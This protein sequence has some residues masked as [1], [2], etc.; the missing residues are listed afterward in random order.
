MSDPSI[1]AP[2]DYNIVPGYIPPDTRIRPWCPFCTMQ[3]RR[4]VSISKTEF[5][6]SS[7]GRKFQKQQ[8]KDELQQKREHLLEMF[9]RETADQAL[10]KQKRSEFRSK[11]R[12]LTP[13]ELDEMTSNK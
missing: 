8:F 13:N 10:S 12:Q 7:C 5:M 11:I 6:C 3:E 4:L 9:E 1:A 2:V